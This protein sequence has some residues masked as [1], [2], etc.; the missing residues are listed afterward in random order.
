MPK[1]P[2]HKCGQCRRNEPHSDQSHNREV[3]LW[4]ATQK[5]ADNLTEFWFGPR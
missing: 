3:R 1:S 5:E 2:T 4:D